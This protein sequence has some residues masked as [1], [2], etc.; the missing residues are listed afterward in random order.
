VLGVQRSGTTT[1][2]RAAA[3]PAAVSAR[4]Q[5]RASRSR[6]SAPERTST[7]KPFA[8]RLF[9]VPHL[10]DIGATPAVTRLVEVIPRA[11]W[12]ILAVLALMALAL[13]AVLAVLARR[14]KRAAAHA[15]ALAGLAATDALTG[16]LNRRGFESHLTTE[17]AR[18]R[19]YGG[20]LAVVFGD[21]RSLKA[22]NDSHG[23]EAGDRALRFVAEILAGQI[24]EGDAC[25]RIGGDEYAVTLVNQGTDGAHAFCDR[26]RTCLGDRVLPGADERLDLTMGV[27]LFPQD[28]D[29]ANELM[30]AADRALYAQRGINVA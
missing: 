24:R 20:T 28:G 15:E 29:T 2:R 9:T 10:R 6:P 4:P 17:L 13:A 11:V 7:R 23:H 19:R 30:A 27:S 21:L 12:L 22:I 25:G 1:V 16:L 3:R 5:R 26:V 14:L 18:A 8:E